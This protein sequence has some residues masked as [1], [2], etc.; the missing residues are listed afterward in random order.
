[1]S[2]NK[3]QNGLDKRL[4][5][6]IAKI[7]RDLRELK[8]KQ[9]IGADVLKVV[10][11]P[12][13]LGVLLAGPLTLLGGQSGTFNVTTTPSSQI[14][15]IWNFA[16]TVYVDNTTN[17]YQWPNG[18]S[19][20]V[21]SGNIFCVPWLDWADSS[22]TTNVRVFKVR[23]SNEDPGAVTHSYYLRFKAYLP[24]DPTS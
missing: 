19:I 8:T 10:G 3:A 2:I 23:I 24:T 11:V 21:G 5:N 4:V 16:F 22:D 13:G 12:N 9:P 17:A 14:L 7:H 1:M 20:T 15:T 6:D 18:S